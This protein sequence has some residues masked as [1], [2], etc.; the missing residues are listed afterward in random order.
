MLKV[1]IADDSA[2]IRERIKN[3]IKLFHEVIVCGEASNGK[4]ALEMII[5]INPDLVILD[6]RMPEMNG[7]EVL[8]KIRDLHIKTKVCILTNYPYSQYKKMCLEKR[9]DYFIHKTE[10]FKKL[11]IVIADELNRI[12]N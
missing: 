6:I 4:E 8:E 10:D 5:K 3:E 2:L 1:I 11:K 9:V 12:N 7:I